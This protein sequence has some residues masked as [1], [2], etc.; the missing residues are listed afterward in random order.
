ML[1]LAIFKKHLKP[2]ILIGPFI[3]FLFMNFLQGKVID[4]SG[5]VC[6]LL[7]QS[8]LR[9]GSGEEFSFTWNNILVKNSFC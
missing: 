2:A 5:P 7:M 6:L 4:L 1:E 3:I 9:V 8:Y